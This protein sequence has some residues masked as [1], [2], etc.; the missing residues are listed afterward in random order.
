[1]VKTADDSG[2]GRVNAK[3]ELQHMASIK[4]QGEFSVNKRF[5]QAPDDVFGQITGLS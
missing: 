5:L 3:G 1:M 2:I 4:A